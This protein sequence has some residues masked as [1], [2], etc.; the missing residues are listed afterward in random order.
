MK[1]N[2]LEPNRSIDTLENIDISKVSSPSIFKNEEFLK[3]V[4]MQ[5]EMIEPNDELFIQKGYSMEGYSP[6]FKGGEDQ[7]LM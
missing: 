2:E 3:S 7:G 5:S 6:K 4:N 1:F